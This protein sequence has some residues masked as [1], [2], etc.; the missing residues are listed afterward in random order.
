MARYTWART[1]A[2]HIG[3]WPRKPARRVGTWPR[4]H[5]RHVLAREHV[6]ST[7]VTQFS[8]LDYLRTHTF[9][10]LRYLK[11]ASAIFYQIFIFTKWQPF[12]N[13]EKCFLFHLKS[14]FRSRYSQIFVFPSS[15]L[16]LP[17]SHCLRGWSKINL[18]F[19]TS[20]IV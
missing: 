16:F 4:K 8:R 6:F 11:L 7:Q 5:V 3:T 17:V 19:M 1:Y 9:I 13:Y 14:S 18:K 20:W 15:P 10:S 12:Q 2:R